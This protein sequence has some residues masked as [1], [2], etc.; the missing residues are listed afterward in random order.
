M[1]RAFMG[2][3]VSVCSACAQARREA[4]GALWGKSVRTWQEWGWRV[5]QDRGHFPASEDTAGLLT[6]RK[7]HCRW[8]DRPPVSGMQH[9]LS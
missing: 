6:N 3:T 8:K 4:H 7:G 5:G 9:C 1:V 2:I